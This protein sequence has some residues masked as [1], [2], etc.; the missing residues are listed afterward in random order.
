M[1]LHVLHRGVVLSLIMAVMDC[2][3]DDSPQWCC[4]VVPGVTKAGRL[5]F[6]DFHLLWYSMGMSSC[7]R[8]TRAHVL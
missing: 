7:V 8:P 6:E 5:S 4:V 2:D 3:D 1:T